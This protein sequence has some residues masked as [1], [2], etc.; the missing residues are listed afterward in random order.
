[1]DER[2]GLDLMLTGSIGSTVILQTLVCDIPKNRKNLQKMLLSRIIEIEDLRL[3]NNLQSLI[4]YA[5]INALY[6]KTNLIYIHSPKVKNIF[7]FL[8]E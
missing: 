1:M 2:A 8:N 7:I 4:E 5:A 6:I 3:D